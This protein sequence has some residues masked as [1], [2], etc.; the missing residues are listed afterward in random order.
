MKK[1]LQLGFPTL[2]FACP[3][4]SKVL[5]PL[6]VYA[7]ELESGLHR[8]RGALYFGDCPT[9]GNR[10]VHFEFHAFDYAGHGPEK[11]KSACL[12]VHSMIRPDKA[13]RSGGELAGQ[14][15]QDILTIKKKFYRRRSNASNKREEPGNC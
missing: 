3:P 5:P 6:G 7:A 12:W 14:I 13:F 2:N 1:G 15:T 4:S 9:F 11:G 10:D 8:W